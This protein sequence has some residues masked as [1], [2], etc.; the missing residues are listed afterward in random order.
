M[1]IKMDI[2]IYEDVDIDEDVYS[3]S[4]KSWAFPKEVKKN[5]LNACIIFFQADGMLKFM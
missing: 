5:V 3:F 2:Y 4:I 1:Y